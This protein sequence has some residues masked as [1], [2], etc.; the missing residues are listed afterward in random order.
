LD[1]IKEAAIAG[2]CLNTHT[3]EELAEFLSVDPTT[4]A[5]WWRIFRNKAGVLMTALAQILAN[6][7]QLS[8]WASG[9]LTTWSE[10]ARKILELIDHC[11]TTFSPDFKF[12]RF[13]WANIFNPYLMFS[14]KGSPAG[15]TGS[16]S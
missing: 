9:P 2:I 16:A 5:R 14:H 4:I 13:A 7:P 10:R 15:N 12:C 6:T 3:I 1:V 8:Y 11:Q